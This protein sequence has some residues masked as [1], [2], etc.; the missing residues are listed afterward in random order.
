MRR[1]TLLAIHRSR[2]A[3]GARGVASAARSAGRAGHD[4][5]RRGDLEALV[6]LAEQYGARVD[7]LE[8]LLGCGPRSVQRVLLRLREAGLVETR[9]VLVGEPAWVIPTRSGLRAAGGGF[10]VWRL[11]LGSLM[12]VAAVNDVRL[13]VRERSLESEW[14]PERVLFKERE[15]GEHLADGVV[16]TGDGQRVAIEV[17]LTVKSGQRV[18]SILDELTGRYDTVLYFCAPG[19]YRQLRG[20]AESGEWPNLGV[21]ELPRPQARVLP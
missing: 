21:R 18:R 12:H 11:R 8:L 14:V 20:L 7:Q 2:G 6:W 4:V 16:V 9:R 10:G 17:E 3:Y 1:R 19:P 13:H 15:P 5:L